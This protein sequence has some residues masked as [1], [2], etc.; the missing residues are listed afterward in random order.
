[1]HLGNS[2]SHPIE[3]QEQLALLAELTKTGV[4]AC[5]AEPGL[6]AQL[7]IRKDGT[8]WLEGSIAKRDLLYFAKFFIGAGKDAT[9]KHPPELLDCM[10]S[11]LSE[12][13]SHYSFS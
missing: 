11:Y 13:S 8:G 10:K 2:P 1:M 9:V 12:L 3:E 5:E 4:Q 6:V 7:H